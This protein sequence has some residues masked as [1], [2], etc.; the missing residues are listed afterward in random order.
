MNSL[1]PEQ[2]NND[3]EHI[4]RAALEESTIR[5][6]NSGSNSEATTVIIINPPKRHPTWTGFH[7]P[8]EAMPTRRRMNSCGDVR[9]IY[10][11]C[12]AQRSTDD[13]CKAAASYFSVC[14]ASLGNTD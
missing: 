14:N 6:A 8:A 13:V 7:A 12:L 4:M 5:T 11:Q 2:D 3:P 9:E 1:Q 10:G